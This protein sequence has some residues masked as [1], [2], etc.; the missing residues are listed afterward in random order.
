[1][2]A[3]ARGVRAMVNA[4]K[5]GGDAV[6]PV[7]L[8]C[9][10]LNHAY[11]PG[12]D[13]AFSI[14]LLNHALDLGCNFFDTATMYGLGENERLIGKAIGARRDEFFLASKCVAGFDPETKRRTLDARPEA[15]KAA[16]DA[17]LQRLDMDVI[18]LYYMHRPDPNVPIEDS[19]GALADLVSAG[20][21]RMIGL[22]EMGEGLLRRAYAVHPI[23]ALQSEY[24]LWVRNPEI[25]VK[26]A[27]EELGIALVAFSPVGRGFL[28]DPPADPSNFH[29]HDMRG[30]RFPRF[31]A[32]H[33][34]ANLELLEG[35]RACAEEV[36]CTVAQLAL[37]WTLAKGENVIPIPGT[38]KLDHLEDNIA[39]G[40]IALSPETVQKLDAHFAPEKVVG[41]RYNDA[42]QATVDTERFPFEIAI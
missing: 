8:G 7:G 12:P 37:A 22:S 15:I 39:A 21:I 14:K 16:C 27:C 3:S 31:S 4:R 29:K 18:D 23:A 42:A 20:K 24:S 30:S 32:E 17:S 13:E 40:R 34:P 6:Y 25:A 9:M 36:G 26:S 41:P 1:M 38:T 11:G 35:A 2:I 33:Y 5:I 19:V 28:A 10:N